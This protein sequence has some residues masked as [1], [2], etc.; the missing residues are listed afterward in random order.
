[1]TLVRSNVPDTAAPDTGKLDTATLV[2]RAC[3]GDV[4]AFEQLV[5][6]Y[7]APMYRLAVRMLGRAGDAEDVVQEAFVTAWRRLSELRSGAAFESWLYQIT[8]NRCLN[9]LRARK[10]IAELDPET[11]PGRSEC[12]PEQ[13]AEISGELAALRAALTTLTPAQR[14]CWLLREAHGRS[15]E[16]IAVIVGTTSTTA[17]RGRIARARAQ[18]AE[19]MRPWR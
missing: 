1:M 11:A 15:Y 5:T 9:V 19:V 8:T 2:I 13:A 7:Q 17:V 14:A 16:E 18:L 6:C 3:D 10:P 12:Q 4:H